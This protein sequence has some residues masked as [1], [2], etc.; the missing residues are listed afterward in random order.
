MNLPIRLLIA[1]DHEIVREGLCL[2]LSENPEEIDVVGQAQ[3]GLEAVLLAERLRPDVI[4]MDLV[5]PDIDGI[6][7]TRRLR[8]TGVM[9]KVIILTSFAEGDRVRDAIQAGATGYL[10]KDV[11]RNDL[12]SAIRSAA[13]GKPTLHP[14][15]QQYLMQQVTTAAAPS[16]FAS[17]TERE[18]DVLR[19]LATGHSNKEIAVRLSLT[20]GTVKGYVSAI[21]SKLD[22]A[23]RTQAALYAVS[24][25]LV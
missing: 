22:M 25:G 19:L 9:S 21:L 17:L 4:L 3:H 23:D 2:L 24:H 6:E 8:A 20:V 13:D 7:A 16:P 1:D 11:L 5:M 14:V 10:L 12:V 18:L 15:V